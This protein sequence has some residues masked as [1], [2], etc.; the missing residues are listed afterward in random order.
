MTDGM[1]IKL[2]LLL[3]A[4][5]VIGYTHTQKEGDVGKNPAEAPE[6]RCKPEPKRKW[7]FLRTLNESCSIYRWCVDPLV[8]RDI[9]VEHPDGSPYTCVEKTRKYNDRRWYRQAGETCS[10]YYWCDR[11]LT[12]EEAEGSKFKR[13]KPERRSVCGCVTVDKYSRLNKR[14]S[15]KPLLDKCYGPKWNFD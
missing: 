15:I 3:L 1:L 10:S 9:G 2:L 5:V 14:T 6:E 7:I 8:C 12:C 4:T 13:C 11:N